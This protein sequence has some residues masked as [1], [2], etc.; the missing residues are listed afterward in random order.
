MNKTKFSLFLMVPLLASGAVVGCTGRG[1]TPS[2]VISISIVADSAESTTM[3]TF[4]KKYKEIPGNENKKFKVVK[5]T[6]YNDY[7]FNSFLYDEL[8][9]IIQVYDY[10]AEYYTNADLDGAGTSLL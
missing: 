1:G 3:N 4:I 10:N 9:D 8:T 5:M 7:I 2:D 6:N